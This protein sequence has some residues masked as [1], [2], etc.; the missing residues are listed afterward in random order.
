MRKSI[1]WLYKYTLKGVLK[2]WYLFLFPLLLISCGP[3]ETKDAS[4]AWQVTFFSLG[5][6]LQF[7]RGTPREAETQKQSPSQVKAYRTLGD[8]TKTLVAQLDFPTAP[9]PVESLYFEWHEGETYQIEVTSQTGQ[10]SFQQVT[11]P[12]STA[13]G[14]LEISVPYGAAAHA[15][16]PS[17]VL[18]D[19]ELTAT[20]LV[21]NGTAAP[22]SSNR[23]RPVPRHQADF[24]VEVCLPSTLTVVKWPEGWT[25]KHTG[26][27]T[28]LTTSGTFTVAGEVWYREVVLKMP[29]LLDTGTAVISGKVRFEASGE[30][31]NFVLQNRED[32]TWEHITE[33]QLQAAT[34][35]EIA[36]QLAIEDVQMPTDD[37]GTADP[38][39]RADTLYHAQPLLGRWGQSPIDVYTPIAHQ[40]VHLRN[41][42]ES[43]LHVVVSSINRDAKSGKVIQFLAPPE[44]VNAGTDMS[45]S[46]ASLPPGTLS[47][48]PLPIYFNPLSAR[49]GEYTREIEVKVWGSNA[50]VLREQRPLH[51]V[52][53][54]RQALFI[55]VLA[56]LASSIGLAGVL[57]HHR[58]IFARFTTKQLIVIA[59]FGATVFVC[60]IIPSTLFLNLI[61]ALLGPVSVLLTGLMNE[62]LYYALLTALLIYI[63][64]S[65]QKAE[66]EECAV[67]N[68]AYGKTEKKPGVILLASAVR[69]LLG[70]VTFGLFTPMEIIYTGTS[71][72]LLETGYRLVQRRGLLAWA[73]AL[74]IC[75]ALAVYVDFQLSIVFYRLFYADWYIA[76]RI[77]VEGFAYTFIGV[78]LGS[79]LGRGL[80][81]VAD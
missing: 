42:S 19:S 26:E 41:H 13:R 37:A 3:R 61:R 65:P 76:M 59:L 74:G 48:I 4:L 62:T 10:V 20:V 14:S 15:N 22:P 33:L 32:T 69:L 39:Q 52:V 75:D 25:A 7:S 46:F 24:H 60:V 72:L 73:V 58:Q 68:R 12:R 47:A 6:E 70:A 50:T 36:A 27:E 53:P 11:A 2:G 34:V 43:T 45:V 8:K 71:V 38:R 16:A 66:Q 51:I 67:E 54:N 81:R 23:R 40:T 5:A 17:L 80:W 35:E 28:C 78:L 63:N 56:V 64:G 79:R 9:R 55:T 21:R 49:A 18:H 77:L 29:R 31:R 1:V 57:R 30:Y 44:A